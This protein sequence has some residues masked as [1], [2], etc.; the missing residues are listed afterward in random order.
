ELQFP[1]TRS[2]AN[3]MPEKHDISTLPVLVHFY[4]VADTLQRAGDTPRLRQILRATN[5]YKLSDQVLGAT[6]LAVELRYMTPYWHSQRVSAIFDMLNSHTLQ[7]CYGLP[8]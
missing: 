1:Y 3:L 7:E 5:C 6:E 8:V 2:P 4:A